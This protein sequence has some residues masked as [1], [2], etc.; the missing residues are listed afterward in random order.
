MKKWEKNERGLFIQGLGH[1]GMATE[2]HRSKVYFYVSHSLCLCCVRLK[3]LAHNFVI[4]KECKE[5]LIIQDCVIIAKGHGARG[6]GEIDP[7]VGWMGEI[8]GPS[9]AETTRKAESRAN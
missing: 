4:G 9:P 1:A 8:D 3:G 7:R 2:L 5:M 6:V